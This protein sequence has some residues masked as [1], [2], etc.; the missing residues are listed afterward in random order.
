[1][2]MRILQMRILTQAP[3]SSRDLIT[4]AKH[5]A[6]RHRETAAQSTWAGIVTASARSQERSLQRYVRAGW[7]QLGGGR[8]AEQVSPQECKSDYVPVERAVTDDR[9][10]LRQAR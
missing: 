4:A 3:A 9:T 8:R 5:K 7:P 10:S 6:T 2:Q 1:M